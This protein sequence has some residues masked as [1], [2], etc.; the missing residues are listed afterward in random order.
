MLKKCVNTRPGS[1]TAPAMLGLALTFGGC[2][3]QTPPVTQKEAPQPQAIQK[4]AQQAAVSQVPA[5][6]TLKRK[7]ALG[8]ITNETNYGRR[9]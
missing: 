4:A 8:R 7:I 9:H 5:A 2:A 1:F 6:P 3:V